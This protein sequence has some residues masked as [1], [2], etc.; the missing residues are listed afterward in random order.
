[1]R[2]CPSGRHPNRSAVALFHD[3]V[4]PPL[5]VLLLLPRSDLEQN[6]PLPRLLPPRR[7]HLLFTRDSPP[8]CSQKVLGSNCRP[9]VTH[10]TPPCR[11]NLDSLP[12][13]ITSLPPNM[14]QRPRHLRRRSKLHPIHPA[15]LDHL[16]DQARL[17][18]QHHYHDHPGPRQ[19]FVRI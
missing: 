18:S 6:D 15:A 14:G 13:P 2:C 17:E 16:E 8:G 7:S 19:L 5:I 4:L 3:Y 10:S 1:M 9:R 12:N 11:P